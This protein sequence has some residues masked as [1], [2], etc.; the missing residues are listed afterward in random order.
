MAQGR[1]DFREAHEHFPLSPTCSTPEQGTGALNQ[2]R[3]EVGVA[4]KEREINSLL[5]QHAVSCYVGLKSLPW[6]FSY[7]RGL[8][9]FGGGRSHPYTPILR[10][11][12]ELRSIASHFSGVLIIVLAIFVVMIGGQPSKICFSSA[13][14]VKC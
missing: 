11:T 5:D 8:T 12:V 4:G 7:W 1:G 13:L 2:N 3:A 9:F 10:I 14:L 6:V